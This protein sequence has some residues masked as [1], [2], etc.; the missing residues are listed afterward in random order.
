MERPFQSWTGAPEFS[1]SSVAC[2]STIV[3]P[4]AITKK[5]RFKHMPFQWNN[6]TCGKLL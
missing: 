3:D 1:I 5:Q 6:R 2:Y 4:A